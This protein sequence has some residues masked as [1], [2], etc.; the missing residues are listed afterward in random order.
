LNRN[1]DEVFELNDVYATKI[2]IGNKESVNFENRFGEMIN[3]QK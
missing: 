2:L 3:K 1:D